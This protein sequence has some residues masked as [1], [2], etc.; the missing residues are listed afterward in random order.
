MEQGVD[1]EMIIDAVLEA[2]VVVVV[3][4]YVSMLRKKH[5]YNSKFSN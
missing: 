3:D 1:I 4:T 2:V 5:S